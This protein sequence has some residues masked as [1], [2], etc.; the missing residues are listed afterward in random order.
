MLRITFRAE[1]LGKAREI[2]GNEKI[3]LLI[4]DIMLPDGDGLSFCRELKEKQEIPV[5]FLSALSENED[6][7]AGLRAGGDDYLAKPY[8][9][10]VLIAR[11]EARLRTKP[12]QGRFLQY[13]KLR[14]DTVKLCG[15]LENEDLNLTQKEFSLLLLLMQHPEECVD[16]GL[17][18][19]T[20]W[21]NTDVDY[22]QVLYTT[23]SRL[24]KKVNLEYSDVQIVAKRKEGYALEKI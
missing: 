7:I 14:L 6:I 2:L 17:L 21:G 12:S 8:D 23:I 22:T 4:L 5:L 1:N 13:G 18:Y 20:V 9:L 10:E 19:R 16:S 11:V 24:K 15:Y 3:D